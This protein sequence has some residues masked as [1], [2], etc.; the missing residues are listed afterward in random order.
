M[1]TSKHNMWFSGDTAY[2]EAF[3][4][5]GQEYGPFDLAAI[6]IGM[7][8]VLV[9]VLMV[10]YLIQIIVIESINIPSMLKS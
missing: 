5:I 3:E 4:A 2:C 8:I 6:A 1:K 7:L 10:Q 9:V